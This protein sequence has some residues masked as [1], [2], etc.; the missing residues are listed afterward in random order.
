VT[1]V[2]ALIAESPRECIRFWRTPELPGVELMTAQNSGRIWRVFHETYVVCVM[3]P[4]T[5]G[6]PVGATWKYRQREFAY[7]PG[8]VSTEEPGEL[9]VNTRVYAPANFWVAFLDPRLMQDAASELAITGLPHLKMAV[10]EAPA[11]Y[12]AFTRLYDALQ[13]DASGL[14]RE[15]RLATC[16]RTLLETCGERVPSPPPR[17]H[18][19][20]GLAREFLRAHFADTIGLA[21]LAAISGLSRFHFAHLF[22]RAYGMSPHACQTQL[23]VAAAR[24]ALRA[25][26]PSQSVDGGFYDQSHLGKHFK[27]AWGLTPGQYAAESAV[28]SLPK[29]TN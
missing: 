28:S 12:A 25:G 16:V 5:G 24:R 1:E 4:A 27:R 6:R 19:G 13:Q 15:T 17:H 7:K 10:T 2:H 23:R 3:P 9:H 14:E 20:V 11:V 8:V 26:M 18:P 22:A 21:D 29:L